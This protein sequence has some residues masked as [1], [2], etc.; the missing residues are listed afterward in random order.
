MK[1]ELPKE[2]NTLNHTIKAKIQK[3]RV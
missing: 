3:K 2:N 1:A